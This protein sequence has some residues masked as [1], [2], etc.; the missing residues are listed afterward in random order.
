MNSHRRLGTKAAM[1]IQ[2][3]KLKEE[4]VELTNKL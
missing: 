2:I 3:D 1:V 4:N